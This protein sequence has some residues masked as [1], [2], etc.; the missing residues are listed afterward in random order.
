MKPAIAPSWPVRVAVPSSDE[1]SPN[2][3]EPEVLMQF[4]LELEMHS[5]FARMQTPE[6][7]AN[8]VRALFAD[9]PEACAAAF[10]L[11]DKPGTFTLPIAVIRATKG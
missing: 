2:G 4:D 11:R 9:A 5:W 10:H 1:A 8:A 6:A 3:L 7:R